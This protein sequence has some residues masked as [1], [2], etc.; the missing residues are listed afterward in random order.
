VCPHPGSCA[1]AGLLLLQ[2]LLLWG[3][4]GP[5]PG[6]L[7]V[8]RRQLL[9]LVLLERCV[10]LLQVH[11]RLLLLQCN[12]M[13]VVGSSQCKQQLNRQQALL[14]ACKQRQLLRTHPHLLQHLACCFVQQAG[15][16]YAQQLAPSW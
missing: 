5:Q 8:L 3:L 16:L 10:L 4:H 9:Q 14:L 12:S 6:L 2:L 1:S 7:V 13:K 15:M 11:R